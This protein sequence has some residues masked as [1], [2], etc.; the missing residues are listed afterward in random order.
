MD[1][2]SPMEILGA[3]LDEVEGLRQTDAKSY[4]PIA[5][6]REARL[7]FD[8]PAHSKSAQSMLSSIDELVGRTVTHVFDCNLKLGEVLIAC[9]DGAFLVLES[10][11]EGDDSYIN[12]INSFG[13][14]SLF[15]YLRPADLL[16]MGLLSKEQCAKFEREEKTK[17]A[18]ETIERLE[19]KVKDARKVLEDFSSTET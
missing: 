5:L 2:R 18:Q 8:A 6:L 19:R 17:E 11:Q 7:V 1:E 16:T 15:D 13:P 3:I 9:S 12:T 14:K 10:S 4:L